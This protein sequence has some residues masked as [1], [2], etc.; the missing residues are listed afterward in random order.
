M[1]EMMAGVGSIPI[2][3]HGGTI[4]EIIIIKLLSALRCPHCRLIITMQI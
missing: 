3:I 2:Y 1:E 4:A